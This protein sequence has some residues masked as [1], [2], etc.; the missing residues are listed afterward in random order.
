MKCD[1]YFANGL[2]ATEDTARL[3]SGNTNIIPVPVVLASYHNALVVALEAL[4][5]EVGSI[6]VFD[7]DESLQ[8]KL[9]NVRAALKAAKEQ[10]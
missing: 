6:I 2:H 9:A 5:D 8:K 4:V 1:T 3:V 7:S 10:A